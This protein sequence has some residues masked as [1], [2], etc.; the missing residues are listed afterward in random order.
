MVEHFYHPKK[1]KTKFCATLGKDQKGKCSY[2]DFC[3]F[4]HSEDELKIKIL[5]RMEKT[6]E[7]FKYTYKTVYCPFNHPHDKSTCEYAHNVQDFRRDPRSTP[8]KAEICR[9][10]N[11]S[12]EISKYEDGGCNF[13][14]A[15]DK[16]HGWKELEYH[17]KFYKTKQ[18]VNADKCSRT[19]CGYL[20]PNETPKNQTTNTSK[21]HESVKESLTSSSQ[22]ANKGGGRIAASE[23]LQSST[24]DDRFLTGHSS[25]QSKLQ[26]HDS[27][28][29]LGRNDE[30]DRCEL[31]SIT[32][33]DQHVR[34]HA[35]T[36]KGNHE[37]DDFGEG[38]T[39]DNCRS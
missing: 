11:V 13:N 19:D 27:V 28:S 12:T 30:D 39:D 16:C 4:A 10:W 8:Y 36:E 24:R 7:F 5:H 25:S 26:K 29:V 37:Y 15:C 1:Y 34:Q 14:E 38:R 20:H 2:S 23:S 21:M 18:C 17:P 35:L 22:K 33:L 3:S 32:D 31:N 6:P 9:K